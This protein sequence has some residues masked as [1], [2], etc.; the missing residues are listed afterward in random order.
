[1]SIHEKS[2]KT[3]K[4]DETK[5]KASVM[6]TRDQGAFS[7]VQ[8]SARYKNK[9]LIKFGRVFRNYNLDK[10]KYCIW[11]NHRKRVGEVGRG[12]LRTELCTRSGAAHRKKAFLAPFPGLHN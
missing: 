5:A 10:M 2:R 4:K 9:S 11:V 8:P 1:M 7:L 12:Q 6:K 3:H